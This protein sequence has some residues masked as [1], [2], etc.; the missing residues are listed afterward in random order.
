MA[1]GGRIELLQAM[2]DS[3]PGDAFCRYALAL[4]YVKLGEFAT[5]LGWF[6]KTIEAD[7]DYCYAYFHKAKTLAASGDA[8]GA[9]R[10]AE[11][12]LTQAL[13]SGDSHAA[14][15]LRGLIEELTEP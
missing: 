14:D 12:G 9:R 11:A 10:V 1:E 7:P 5:A 6:D 3:E 2:L 15:E 13:S 8:P 4:E